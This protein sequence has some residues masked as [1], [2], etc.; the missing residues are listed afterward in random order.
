MLGTFDTINGEYNLTLNSGWQWNS[1]VDP[2]VTISFNERSKG[3]VSFKSFIPS[4]GLSVNGR[5]LTT[6]G[7]DGY[8]GMK[9]A[10]W[11]H[12][13]NNIERNNFYGTQYESEIE[14]V[15]N[16]QPSIV[17]SFK[18]INYEGTQSKINKYTGSTESYGADADNLS[19]TVNDGEYYNLTDKK[20][21]W[22][23]S[24][25]TDLQTGTVA[26]FIS[27]ENKWFNKINGKATTLENLDTSELSVQGLG[28]AATITSTPP[29]EADV[30]ITDTFD[31]LTGAY[32]DD[33]LTND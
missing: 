15:F 1:T 2:P 3:W 13:D 19:V 24:F 26:E 30:I 32:G 8:D 25:T 22:V 16:D 14:V 4:T 27:K 17:K 6:P 21:W 20:G 9:L 5:Y 28:F 7:S 33:D 11:E 31:G 23:E 18:A 10:P 12:Y 29:V